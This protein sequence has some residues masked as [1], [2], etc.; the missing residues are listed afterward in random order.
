M[1]IAG[2]HL[3]KRHWNP[4]PLDGSPADEMIVIMVEDSYDLIVSALARARRRGLGWR[5]E[6]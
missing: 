3:N 4:V 1:I 6:C 2:D 5:P